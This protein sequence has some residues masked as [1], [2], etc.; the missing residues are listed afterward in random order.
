MLFDD[1]II[2][3]GLS[4]LATALGLRSQGRRILIVAGSDQAIRQYPNSNIPAARGSR[5]GMG[6]YWHGVIPLSLNHCPAGLTVAGWSEL[7]GQFYAYADLHMLR[8]A[9]EYFVP[10]RPIR[11]AAHFLRL[12]GE[13]S[14]VISDDNA[15]RV[16][17][18][19]NA[20]NLQRVICDNDRYEARHIWLCAGALDTPRM[21]VRSRLIK[22]GPRPVSDHVIGYAGILDAN[23]DI[24]AMMKAVR[25]NRDGVIFPFRFSENRAHFYTLRPARFDFAKLDT[26]FAKRAIFGLPTSRLLSGL[27]GNFSLGLVSEAL[28]NKLGVFPKSE[29]YSVYF[30]TTAAEAYLL[31]DDGNITVNESHGIN[32]VLRAA[33]SHMPFDQVLSTRQPTLYIPGIHLHG[34]LA[35]EECQQFGLGREFPNLHVV[36]ASALHDIGPEHHSFAMMAAAYNRA[37]TV[38]SQD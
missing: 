20:S 36:D 31:G 27:A 35:R 12:E 17:L 5:G 8:G 22:S 33:Q 25:R 13:G 19:Q 38:S 9:E 11:P 37:I 28:Y 1:I 15:Q 24:E 30:Q 10:H 2:G 23:A 4:A 3:S 6:Q 14:I 16:E 7:A 21:L 18:G 32:E 26:G 34:S 29:R